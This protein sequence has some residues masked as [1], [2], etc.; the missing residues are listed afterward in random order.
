LNNKVSDLRAVALIVVVL[1]TACSSGEPEGAACP[2]CNAISVCGPAGACVSRF[3]SFPTTRG[4]ISAM[5]KGPD[6]N[7]WFVNSSESLVGKVTP[8]G[9]VTEYPVPNRPQRIAAGPDGRLWLT[10][11]AS[12]ATLTVTGGFSALPASQFTSPGG[13]TSGP[14]GNLWVAE[15]AWLTRLTTGGVSTRFP[16]ADGSTATELAAGPDGNLWA[17]GQDGAGGARIARCSPQGTVTEF[18]LP[19]SASAQPKELSRL[20]G[21]GDGNVWF[22]DFW[23]NQIGRISPEGTIAAFPVPSPASG[24]GEI[25]LGADRNVWFTENTTHQISRIAPNGA[26]TEFH[27]GEDVYPLS[28]TSGADGNIWFSSS[29]QIVR[30]RMP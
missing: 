10:E 16:L 27:A 15:G 6:G 8:S 18:P 3:T 7:V 4:F 5:A 13:I 29:G 28:I 20:V 22:L 11:A 21:G 1:A 30:F 2:P 23:D 9:E 17:T 14:D 19:P 24:L 26:I 25:T 12:V